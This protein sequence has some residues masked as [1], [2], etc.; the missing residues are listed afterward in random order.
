MPCSICLYVD[1]S[2][3]TMTKRLLKRGETSGR[4]DDNEETIKNRLRTFHRETEPVIEHYAKQGKLQTVNAENDPDNVFEVV[5][6]VFDKFEG[7]SFD[8]GIFSFFL[9]FFI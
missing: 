6:K 3:E 2:D 1:V 9:K 5:K 4:V 8:E 7:F